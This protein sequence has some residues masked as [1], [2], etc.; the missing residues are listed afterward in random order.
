MSITIFKTIRFKVIT[1]IN[2]LSKFL[3]FLSNNILDIIAITNLLLAVAIINLILL[4]CYPYK[5]CPFG[6]FF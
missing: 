3:A 2:Y 1:L 6:K 5:C 4:L